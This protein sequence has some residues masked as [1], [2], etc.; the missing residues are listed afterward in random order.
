VFVRARIPSGGSRRVEG[1]DAVVVVEE[2]RDVGRVQVVVETA[3][4]DLVEVGGVTL[5][6]P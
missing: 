2:K 5:P 6:C 1:A 4:A 3:I